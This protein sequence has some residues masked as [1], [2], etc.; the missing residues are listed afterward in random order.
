M[1]TNKAAEFMRLFHVVLSWIIPSAATM[2][3]WASAVAGFF[4]GIADIVQYFRYSNGFPE[5]DFTMNL[6]AGIASFLMTGF[7]IKAIIRFNIKESGSLWSSVALSSFMAFVVAFLPRAKIG[8]A[9][10]PDLF[11]YLGGLGAMVSILIFISLNSPD[12]PDDLP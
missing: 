10:S 5:S 2:F 8:S 6:I 1:T 11:V 4:A 12:T 9:V 7:S 3:I